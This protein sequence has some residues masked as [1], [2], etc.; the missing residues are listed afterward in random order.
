MRRGA[1]RTHLAPDL[2]TARPPVAAAEDTLRV[3]D[4]EEALA[5]PAFQ[6]LPA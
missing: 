5:P 1:P 4:H 3:I 2:R 6:G